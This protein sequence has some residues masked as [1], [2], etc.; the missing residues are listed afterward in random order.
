MQLNLHHLEL[1]NFQPIFQAKDITKFLMTQEFCLETLI[2]VSDYDY[3]PNN[4]NSTFIIPHLRKLKKLHVSE[5]FIIKNLPLTLCL[6]PNITQFHMTLK[7]DINLRGL[8]PTTEKATRECCP[9]LKV[10]EI[11]I[12]QIAS[13]ELTKLSIWLPNIIKI[14]LANCDDELLKTIFINFSQIK[15][16]KI[17]ASRFSEDMDT[18]VTDS[19]I[20]GLPVSKLQTMR[21]LLSCKQIVNET[22]E[23]IGYLKGNLCYEIISFAML[24]LTMYVY[25]F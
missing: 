18:W 12:S 15:T 7:I 11:Y 2:L 22:S 1:I 9:H 10:V 25:D 21:T 17:G 3:V 8:F 24:T 16:L 4:A 5:H 20:I 23:H 13:L 19:G 14:S 6:S